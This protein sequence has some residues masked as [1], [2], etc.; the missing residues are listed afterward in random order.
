MIRSAFLTLCNLTRRHATSWAAPTI[1]LHWDGSLYQKL[2]H[3]QQGCPQGLYPGLQVAFQ[4]VFLDIL[5][6][7]PSIR[8]N[9]HSAASKIATPFVGL[10]GVLNGISD[11]M[12][13]KQVI[14][15]ER[16][17]M[18]IRDGAAYAISGLLTNVFIPNLS[19]R[20]RYI[21]TPS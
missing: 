7:T 6:R 15:A 18:P 16:Q 17:P 11:A 12:F 14:V 10:D 5:G 20:C 3:C 1:A 21:L 2:H 13:G 8:A 4:A 9:H 19:G